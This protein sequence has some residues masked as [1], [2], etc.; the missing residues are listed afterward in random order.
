M[1]LDLA[2]EAPVKIIAN[3]MYEQH[4]VSFIDGTMNPDVFLHDETAV[5]TYNYIFGTLA[6]QENTLYIPATQVN[7]EMVAKAVQYMFGT[8]TEAERIQSFATWKIAS[9]LVQYL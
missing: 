9:P 7:P 4:K 8:L 6:K 2:Y 3:K 5:A 1:R